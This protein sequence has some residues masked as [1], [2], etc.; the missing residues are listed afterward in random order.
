MEEALGTPVINETGLSGVLL[1]KLT[2][3]PKS[4]S[5]AN[6]AL[7]ELGLTLASAKRPIE[8]AVLS[9]PA[10]APNESAQNKR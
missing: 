10:S 9:A 8:S 2:I 5:S 6:D 4:L 1:A 3:A 7:R